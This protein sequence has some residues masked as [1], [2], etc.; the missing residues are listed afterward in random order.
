MKVQLFLLSLVLL[1]ASCSENDCG[2]ITPQEETM[3]FPP[4]TSETIWETKTP[5]NMGWN[6]TNLQTLYSYLEQKNTKGFIM[7][8][9]GRI[10]V[11]KYFNDI[12]DHNYSIKI[13]EIIETKP[14]KPTT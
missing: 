10:V 12:Q 4:I 1:T 6:T 11:E 7:L 5:E 13:I 14:T 8:H 2:C 3:Y 9:N